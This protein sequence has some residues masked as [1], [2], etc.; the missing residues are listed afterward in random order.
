MEVHLFP[1]NVLMLVTAVDRPFLLFFRNALLTVCKRAGT[2]V[3][4][5]R[6]SESDES[7]MSA[8]GCSNNNSDAV[9]PD[10]LELGRR[11]W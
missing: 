3:F 10:F 11:H 5:A 7:L 6:V 4:S 8:L 1:H 9:D 2:R